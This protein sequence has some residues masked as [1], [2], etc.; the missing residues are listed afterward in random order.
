MNDQK[1]IQELRVNP[2]SFQREETMID[3]DKAIENFQ[4]CDT[5][6]IGIKFIV[7]Q[8]EEGFHFNLKEQ[9]TQFCTLLEVGRVKKD[10]NNL[11]IIHLKK[12]ELPTN[13]ILKF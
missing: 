10:I 9:V 12:S 1:D 7:S 5:F 3:A 4:C 8:S 2:R 6:F 13:L 11:R